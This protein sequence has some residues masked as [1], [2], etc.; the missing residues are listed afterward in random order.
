MKSNFF[1]QLLRFSSFGHQNP[2]SGS[3]SSLKPI[4]NPDFG[5][6]VNS[7]RDLIPVNLGRDGFKPGY[8]KATLLP[9]TPIKKIT[10]LSA[11]CFL[12][13]AEDFSSNNKKNKVFPC[14]GS[15]SCLISAPE[16]IK[17]NF[18]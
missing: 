15:R 2:G 13:G 17:Q 12:S 16:I 9:P 8:R 18:C 3:G 6:V 1:F 14:L 10:L 5:T 11:G 4:R 7:C